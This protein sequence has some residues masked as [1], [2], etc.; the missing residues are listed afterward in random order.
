M[1]A[2]ADQSTVTFSRWYT[3]WPWP[4]A[5]GRARVNMNDC[6][7]GFVVACFRLR[8]GMMNSCFVLLLFICFYDLYWWKFSTNHAFWFFF[9]LFSD[10]V[11]VNVFICLCVCV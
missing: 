2:D 5:S 9:Y 3:G 1:A 7:S 6:R 8:S 10:L 4:T 11:T